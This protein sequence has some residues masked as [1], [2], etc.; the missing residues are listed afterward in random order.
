LRGKET[1]NN[2][3][4]KT[5]RVTRVKQREPG[6]KE[7]KKTEK[8]EKEREKETGQNMEYKRGSRLTMKE[9]K[10]KQTPE[11]KEWTVASHRCLELLFVSHDTVTHILFVDFL[12]FIC[13]Q[14]RALFM[15]LQQGI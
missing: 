13:T 10:A 14:K 11:K 6:K 8:K 4:K 3:R 7:T 2:R 12:L 15:F 9:E 5:R 1:G